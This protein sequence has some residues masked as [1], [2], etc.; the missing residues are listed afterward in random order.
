[1]YPDFNF[2]TSILLGIALSACCGFRIFIPLLAASIA[3]FNNWIQFPVEMQWLAEWPTIVCFGIAALVE[4]GAYYIPFLDNILD[5]IAIPLA[6]IAGTILAFSI[7]PFSDDQQPLLRWGLGLLAGG[8][9]AGSIQAGTAL[10][11][12]FTTK[13][14]VGAGNMFIATGENALAVTGVLLSF[15]VPV[16]TAVILVLL[17]AWVIFRTARRLILHQEQVY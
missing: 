4:I 15:F 17:A 3:G 10:V 14:T 13:A 5:S 12:L 16:L 1:M 7:I 11:R 9:T 8:G 2:Y 6:V